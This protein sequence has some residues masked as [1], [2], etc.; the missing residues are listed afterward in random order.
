MACQ[1]EILLGPEDRSHLA[2]A[3]AALDEI[4]R[5]ESQMTVYR[6][7]SEILR[8]NRLAADAPVKVEPR[9]YGL[10]RMARSLGRE[11]RGA[12]DISAGAL[13]RAWG[14]LDRRGRLPDPEELAA[15]RV[16]SGWD[17]LEFDD[18]GQTIFFRRRGVELNLGAIGKGFA[19]DLAAERLRRE[20]LSNFFLH[21]G[22]SSMLAM[23]DSHDGPGWAVSLRDPILRNNTL[24]FLRLVNQAMSASGSGEQHFRA[25]GKF[26]GHILD[27]RTGRPASQN[28][29]AS[30]VAPTAAA[31]EALSTAFFVMTEEEV[32]AYSSSHPAVGIILVRSGEGGSGQAP[33]ALGITLQRR[34]VD[35]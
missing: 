19:L 13:I 21:A 14:F 5:L 15:A 27:A 30:A 25:G 20:G 33:L 6:D 28:L 1:F 31:A 17:Q 3:H 23:G 22:H 11:T 24:G 8:L 35:G 12:F 18:A 34:E 10:L 32:R 9:L 29:L 7:D 2:P 16:V 4:D 26:F